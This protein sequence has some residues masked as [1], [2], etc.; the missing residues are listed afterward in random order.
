MPFAVRY[1][2]IVAVANP[3]ALAVVVLG[4]N[5]GISGGR[6]GPATAFLATAATLAVAREAAVLVRGRRAR[7]RSGLPI[8]WEV[9]LREPFWRRI[10]DAYAVL[11]FAAMVGAAAS[12][13]G[14]P[15][16]AAGMAATIAMLGTGVLSMIERWSP[17]CLMFAADGLHVGVGRCRLVL[18]WND[19]SGVEMSG[20][21]VELS[22]LSFQ[23]AIASI[24]PLGRRAGTRVWTLLHD[25]SGVTGRLHLSAAPSGV[26]A[27]TLKRAI[28]EATARRA[29]MQ[30]N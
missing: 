26:D 28:T 5:S 11:A 8:E 9:P 17:R 18:P 4:W 10:S 21:G 15:G 29:A 23:R 1:D 16:V 30:P 24:V 22:L 25:G 3:I 7:A 12:L 20:D 19:I 27:G 14:F 2:R 13:V 6:M